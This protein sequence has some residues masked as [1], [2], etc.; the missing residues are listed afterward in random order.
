MQ[1]HEIAHTVTSIIADQVTG[2]F[3]RIQA[4]ITEQPDISLDLLGIDE[5]EHFELMMNIEEAFNID[6]SDQDAESLI[7]FGTLIEFIQ[8]HL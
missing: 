1:K 6:I 5:L 4:L 7:T 8:E 2:D 3:D